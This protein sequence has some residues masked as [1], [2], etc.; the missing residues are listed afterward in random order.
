MLAISADSVWSHAVFAASYGLPFPLLAEDSPHW[1][2]SR[3][4]G[5]YD[6]RLNAP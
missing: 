2:I 3:A 6:R 1:K 4:Y 5:V